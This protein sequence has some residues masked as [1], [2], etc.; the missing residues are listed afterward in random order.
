MHT[1]GAVLQLHAYTCLHRVAT[2]NQG[3]ASR[4]NLCHPQALFTSYNFQCPLLVGLLQ[5]AIIVPVRLQSV[6]ERLLY[7]CS[8]AM[9]VYCIDPQI[10]CSHAQSCNLEQ[11]CYAVAR[12]RLEAKT[13]RA[14]VP[15]AFVNVLNL[16]CGLVGERSSVPKLRLAVALHHRST[17]LPCCCQGSSEANT[18]FARPAAGTGGLNVPMFI[19]LRRFTL[20]TTMLLERIMYKRKHDRSTYG[21]V[22]T[23]ILGAPS[24]SQ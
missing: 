8:R 2:V 7:S 22:G 5:M 20:I 18:S 6:R 3:R 9:H 14:V 23:M 10:P 21:A 19:A 12:P 1:T 17:T 15:L 24:L 16:V 11:V 13:F 4:P